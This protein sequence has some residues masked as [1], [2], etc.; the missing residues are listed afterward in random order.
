MNE[1]TSLELR[2]AIRDKFAWPGGYEIYG[3]CSDGGVLCCDCMRA[4]YRQIAYARRHHLRYGWRVE[5]VTCTAY[6]DEPHG[7]DHCGKVIE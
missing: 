5:A 2:R 7:C 6:D 1:L 3:V 4:E